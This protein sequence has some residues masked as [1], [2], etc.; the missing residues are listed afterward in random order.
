MRYFNLRA[1]QTVVLGTALLSLAGCGE[2]KVEVVVNPLLAKLVESERLEFVQGDLYQL[3]D[4]AYT[5]LMTAKDNINAADSAF[6]NLEQLQAFDFEKL[7]NNKVKHAAL[8]QKEKVLSRYQATDSEWQKH[9]AQIKAQYAAELEAAQQELAQNK[10]NL[11]KFNALLVKEQ[12]A[13]DEAVANK[14]KGQQELQALFNQ[15]TDAVNKDIIDKR[16]PIRKFN[17]VSLR[18][19]ITD[20]KGGQCPKREV[21]DYEMQGHG[22]KQDCYYLIPARKELF[23]LPSYQLGEKIM[24]QVKQ[25]QDRIGDRHRPKDG[26]LYAAVRDTEQALKNAKI[27]AENQFGP[28]YK[29]K[30]QVKHAENTYDRVQYRIE[31]KISE[32]Q[33]E[34]F[35]QSQVGSIRRDVR[36]HL[37]AFLESELKQQLKTVRHEDDIDFADAIKVDPKMQRS[38]LVYQFKEGHKTESFLF[39]FNA[40]KLAKQDHPQLTADRY[41]SFPVSGAVDITNQRLVRALFQAD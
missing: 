9:V 29:I 31:R 1:V 34:Q 28:V 16:L 5:E 3:P 41:G 6:A 2:K 11:A 21:Y 22:Y 24:I 7:S 37:N 32:S 25:Q 4:E 19:K 30:R 36:R 20:K 17:N 26:S 15:Y 39:P 8:E 18:Y 38:V 35:V 10:A 23:K 13:F 12:K 40:T 27:I 33:H 14:E